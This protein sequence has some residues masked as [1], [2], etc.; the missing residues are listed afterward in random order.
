MRVKAILWAYKPRR[1]GSCNIKIYVQNKG[2]KHYRKTDFYA[3]PE[4]WD[5]DLGCLIGKDSLEKKTN[6]LLERLKRTVVAEL[7][8]VDTSL[9]RFIAGH[10]D[11]CEQGLHNIAKNTVKQ[12][13]SHLKRLHGYAAV[14]HKE[15]ISFDDIH[16]NFYT[17]FKQYLMGSG[18]GPAGTSKHIRILKKFMRLALELGHHENTDFQLKA[19]AGTRVPAKKKI[20]LTKDEIDLMA[21]LNLDGQLA[22]AKERDRFIVSYY[23]LL[24][25][26]DS[27]NISRGNIVAHDGRTYYRNVAE[28]TAHESFVPVSPAALAILEAREFDLSGGANQDSNRKLKM[29]AALAGINTNMANGG[30]GITPKSA[31]MTTHTARRSAATNLL[32]D[33]VPISEIMQLGGWKNEATLRHYL[34]AGGI[35]LA[36]LSADR[37]FFL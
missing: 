36:K 7:S 14:A 8:G 16:L 31:L 27:V 3:L 25:Y 28:K 11:E 4:N 13:K 20:Y 24:R 26:G 21:G 15:D 30:D 12:Y 33:G 19:F 10:V 6:K 17:D 23:L 18:C 9:L 32:L 5:K 37:A 35:Q 22:L 1:D 34:L 29:I 2:G